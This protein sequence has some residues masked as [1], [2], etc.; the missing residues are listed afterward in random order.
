M[1]VQNDGNQAIGSLG[2]KS[3]ESSID[4]D[5]LHKIIGLLSSQYSDPIGSMLREYTSNIHDAYEGTGRDPHG[6]VSL[7]KDDSKNQNYLSFKDDGS[8]MNLEIF[9]SIFVKYGKSTKD[10]SNTAIGGFGL[11]SKTAFSYTDAFTIISRYDGVIYTYYYYKGEKGL[12]AYDLLHKESTEEGNGTEI[13][14]PIKAIDIYSVKRAVKQLA[15]FDNIYLE[16][17]DT[18]NDYKIIEGNYF[19]FKQNTDNRLHVCL[20]KVYYPLPQSFL[21]DA[22]EKYGEKKLFDTLP[23]ALKFKN[24]ELSPTISRENFE[25]NED[26][27]TL[28]FKRLDDSLQEL[29]SYFEKTHKTRFTKE[30]SLL[31]LFEEN[32]YYLNLDFD[33]HIIRVSNSLLEVKFS[34]ELLDKYKFTKYELEKS[35]RTTHSFIN[36]KLEYSGE[37]LDHI[38]SLKGGYIC[39]ETIPT[40]NVKTA[41]VKEYLQNIYIYKT[42]RPTL[43]FYQGEL[44]L[45]LDDKENWRERIVAYQA[46]IANLTRDLKDYGAI[47]PTDDFIVE[48]K[49]RYKRNKISEEIKFNWI[50]SYSKYFKKSD[51]LKP[52]SI[53][54]DRSLNNCI[55]VYGDNKD[56]DRLNKF[57]IL[58]SN[59]SSFDYIKVMSVRKMDMNTLKNVNRFINIHDILHMNNKKVIRK[60][61]REYQVSIIYS[62]FNG[63]IPALKGIY[64]KLVGEYN[65]AITG[66]SRY[67]VTENNEIVKSIAELYPEFLD[68]ELINLY[69][70]IDKYFKQVPLL[71]FLDHS[72]DEESD[73]KKALIPYLKQNKNKVNPEYY[74]KLSPEEEGWLEDWKNNQEYF[75][76]VLMDTLENNKNLKEIKLIEEINIIA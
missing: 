57:T 18:N 73:Y 42:R 15:Y 25:Y 16:G 69:E 33:G 3:G 34:H 1:I 68:T 22:N 50:S 36:S 67:H 63:K 32:Y 19:K 39:D 75:R 13:R 61:I 66:Y 76:E 56:I 41:Y 53:L 51:L 65:N 6:I 27:K 37:E 38:T 12:P 72:S 14:I 31:D 24:G 45:D 52:S 47:V 55:I 49:E 59:L 20:E 11:G 70:R 21:D 40:R 43:K 62:H 46:C 23:I 7:W 10:K 17:F 9:E 28:L 30:D 54:N 4:N 44:T 64:D 60:A 5:D 29:K 26:V 2:L 35:F 48:Y 58:I 74:L 8:G 71:R